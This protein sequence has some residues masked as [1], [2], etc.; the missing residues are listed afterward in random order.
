[1]NVCRK[2]ERKGE[3]KKNE[4]R[5]RRTKQINVEENKN[6]KLLVSETQYLFSQAST[7]TLHTLHQFSCS[8]L[9]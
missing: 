4:R 7:K 8:L 6:R 2:K 3:R 5:N 1:M 9:Y